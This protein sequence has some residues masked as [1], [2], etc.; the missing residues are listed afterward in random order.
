MVK[1]VD[2]PPR[3]KP[4]PTGNTDAGTASRNVLNMDDKKLNLDVTYP[5]NAKVSLSIPDILFESANA[6][7]F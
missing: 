5:K 1:L 6:K 3:K 2:I 7:N 4:V